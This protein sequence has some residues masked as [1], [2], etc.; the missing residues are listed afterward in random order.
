MPSR[1]IVRLT[2][3]LI[4]LCLVSACVQRAPTAPS[5]SDDAT[6]TIS[7]Q[8]RDQTIAP[9]GHATLTVAASGGGSIAYQWYVGAAGDASQAIGGATAAT[10]VTPDLAATTRYWV[11]ASAS[12]RTADPATVTVN[13]DAAA[14]TITRQPKNESIAVGQTARLGV[15]ASGSGALSYQWFQGDSGVTAN[16]IGG[17]TDAKYTTPALTDTA[18]YWVRVSNAVGSADSTTSTVTVSASP[19]PSPDPAPSPSPTPDPTPTPPPADPSAAAYENEVLVLVNAR[20][21]AGATCGGTSYPAT[22][23]LAMN[24]NLRTAARGHSVDMAAQNYFS[25]T[26]L[27]GRS[28][29]DRMYAAGYNGAGPYG[30]NIAAGYGTAAAAVDGWMNSTDH[31]TAIM[32]GSFHVAGVGYGYGAASSYR[33]YWTMDFGGN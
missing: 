8:P 4:G 11:R 33:Y 28:F 26:S 5:G 30:E 20:R 32:N 24:E 1:P 2:S 31:C 17:A 3:A 7:V 22:G 21:A 27:D 29:L 16:P 13:V 14:P 25:H 9:G 10:Y 19:A 18:H 12:G 15:E 23:P 6:L